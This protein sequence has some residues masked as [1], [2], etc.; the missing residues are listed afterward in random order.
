MS[1]QDKLQQIDELQQQIAAHGKLPEEVL[2][3]INYKFRLEW[4][5]NS[6]SMEGNTLTRIETK[7]VMTHNITVKDKPLNDIL[8][9]EGHDKV[10]NTL[11]K[12]GKGELNISEKRIKE[13]HSIIKFEDEAEKKKM[14]G[15]WK[16]F[17]NYVDNDDPYYFTPHAE[18]PHAMHELINWVNAEGEKIDRKVKE[19]LHPVKLAAE[20]HIRFIAIHP[21]HDGNGRMVRI[22]TNLILISYDYPPVYVD[23]T[24]DRDVYYNYLR[25]I[26]RNGATHDMFYEFITGLVIRSQQTVLDAI[27]GKDIEEPDDID[28]EIAIFKRMLP[29]EGN[30]ENV[31]S[32]TY[33]VIEELYK[34][35]F[36]PMYDRLHS[37]LHGNFYDLF[38]GW[39]VRG[40]VNNSNHNDQNKMHIDNFFRTN[41]LNGQLDEMG[42]P[43]IDNMALRFYMNGFKRNG[44]NAFNVDYSLEII[45]HQ[46]KY[47][48]RN[49]NKTI[50]EKLYSQPLT[51]DEVQQIIQDAQK[52]VLEAIKQRVNI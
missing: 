17:N 32:K 29:V 41:V 20:F 7:A 33:D 44:I 8:E 14:I 1:Y 9:M 46:Y 31:L 50:H 51:E 13:I 40:F 5:Y 15:N 11:M 47:D 28:K 6:N 12:I 45:F 49:N 23:K 2:K 39:D 10:V 26:Q 16:T 42:K 37:K 36:S 4:N 3:K 21:F 52:M 22:L 27:A 24:T 25:D 43:R 35:C 38:N 30:G 19:A 48:V 34:T 18:V